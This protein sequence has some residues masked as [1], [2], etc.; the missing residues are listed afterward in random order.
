MDVPHDPVQRPVREVR[1][2][3]KSI[4]VQKKIKSKSEQKPENVK[5]FSK[6][7]QSRIDLFTSYRRKGPRNQSSLPQNV[8]CEQLCQIEER[9]LY[10]ILRSEYEKDKKA[11]IILEKK[12]NSLKTKQA[13]QLSDLRQKMLLLTLNTSSHRPN[14]SQTDPLLSHSEK[15]VES[16]DT[17]TI[18]IYTPDMASS[19]MRQA[20]DDL[21]TAFVTELQKAKSNAECDLRFTVASL[22]QR[23]AMDKDFEIRK[24]EAINE[25]KLIEQE[26]NHEN[27]VQKLKYQNSVEIQDLQGKIDYLQSE[28]NSVRE[29]NE[30]LVRELQDTRDRVTGQSK[31][32][33]RLQIQ[34]EDTIK[35]MNKLKEYK[36]T[37]QRDMRHVERYQKEA[38]KYKDINQIILG[39]F[40]M[41]EKERDA[42]VAQL[43]RG[44]AQMERLNGQRYL[45]LRNRTDEIERTLL[46]T[47][48]KSK[49]ND[50]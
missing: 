12:I 2:M 49:K 38:A 17:Q 32:Y 35:E 29:T 4:T 36:E 28:L 27:E 11:R 30:E 22:E 26:S 1:P 3:R 50:K 19:V 13:E 23:L 41:L 34:L 14:A 10:E 24:L 42:L 16:K 37:Y 20:K 46:G 18:E 44:V 45:D 25:R 43:E 6:E 5:N 47:Y 40:A 48:E 15:H 33:S 9:K 8:V 21:L 7:L 39:E 31:S